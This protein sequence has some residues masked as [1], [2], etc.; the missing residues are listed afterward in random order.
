MFDFE[1]K[2][3]IFTCAFQAHW[4][5]PHDHRCPKGKLILGALTDPC[6]KTFET[7]HLNDRIFE[8]ALDKDGTLVRCTWRSTCAWKFRMPALELTSVSCSHIVSHLL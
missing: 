2:C 6:E 1:N 7:S 3:T 4:Q 8:H 5:E